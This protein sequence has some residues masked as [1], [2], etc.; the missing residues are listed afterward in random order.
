MGLGTAAGEMML[1]FDDPSM[2]DG[3][4][5]RPWEV[6]NAGTDDERHDSKKARGPDWGEKSAAPRRLETLKARGL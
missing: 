4:G 5:L 6:L 2:V 1:R 3:G